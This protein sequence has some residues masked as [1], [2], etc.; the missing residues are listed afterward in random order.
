MTA[1]NAL[2]TSRV[3]IF[4]RDTSNERRIRLAYVNIELW[5]DSARL[6]IKNTEIGTGQGN[7]TGAHRSNNCLPQINVK[8]RKINQEKPV[9]K[10][11]EKL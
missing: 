6:L 10:I 2:K 8:I 4:F 7:E 5:L 1:K 11:K 3:Y 9:V